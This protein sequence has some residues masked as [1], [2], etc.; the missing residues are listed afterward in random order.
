MQAR[1]RIL[2]WYGEL[3]TR[4]SLLK[5]GALF[6]MPAMAWLMLFLVLPGMVLVIVSFATR[7]TYGQLE[8]APDSASPPH[9][10][11]GR[12]AAPDR[13]GPSSL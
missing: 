5:R 6:L 1:D 11:S 8:W 9:D 4:R 13:K 10:R 7:G 3:T 2:S 12:G